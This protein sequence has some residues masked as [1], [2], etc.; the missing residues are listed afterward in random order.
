MATEQLI[1]GAG[2]STLS[3]S[4]DSSQTTLSVASATPFPTT[5]NFRI[6]IGSELLKVTGVSGTTFTVARGQEGTTGVS[7]GSGENVDYELTAGAMDAIRAEMYSV[8]AY[9]SRPS[10]ARTGA[11][12]ES[13]D[14]FLLSRYNGSSW[15]EYGPLFKITPPAS[16]FD[17]GFS[18]FQQSS[19]TLT[20]NGSSWILKLPAETNG[21][22]RGMFKSAPSTPYT[23]EFGIRILFWPADFV[24]AGPCFKKSANNAHIHFGCAYHNTGGNKTHVMV[25]KYLGNGTFNSTY[26]TVASSPRLGALNWPYF[27]R[28]TNDGTFRKY[29]YSQDGIKWFE[30][31]ATVL[32]SFDT[33]DQVGFGAQ[34]SNNHDTFME[35]FHYREY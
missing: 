29:Q 32:S 4:I 2:R 27:F 19:A 31:L 14:G 16:N 23:I 17:S 30:F 20:Q 35:I 18:W 5:G 21:L 11:I 22:V 34:V 10:S 1:N 25:D 7:H 28:I 3:S 26:V 9:A 15:D 6:R 33:M 8:G 13:T 24:S 12:Y